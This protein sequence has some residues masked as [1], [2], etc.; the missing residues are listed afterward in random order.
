M[1]LLG[2][3]DAARHRCTPCNPLFARNEFAPDA[4]PPIAEGEIDMRFGPG[5]TSAVGYYSYSEWIQAT[6]TE[7]T[8]FFG[9]IRT[10][11]LPVDDGSVQQSR[12]L[13]TNTVGLNGVASLLYAS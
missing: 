12:Q 7:P 6:V 2:L 13:A 8:P 1:A 5:A 10:I 3:D 9:W 11:A 4:E